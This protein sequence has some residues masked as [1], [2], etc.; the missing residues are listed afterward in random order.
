MSIVYHSRSR[1]SA[2]RRG[3]SPR[4]SRRCR[5]RPA[6][7]WSP[8]GCDRW[9]SSSGDLPGRADGQ[10]AAG[11]RAH[12]GQDQQPVDR[13][14]E[15]Q[16]VVGIQRGFTA[17]AAPR[18]V[19]RRPP[20]ITARGG[21]PADPALRRRRD[22]AGWAASGGG[23][24]AAVSRTGLRAP[25]RHPSVPDGERHRVAHLVGGQ[26]FGQEPDGH[27]LGAQQHGGQRVVEDGPV[28]QV[29]VVPRDGIQPRRDPPARQ[30]QRR[31]VRPARS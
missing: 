23:L 10:D 14:A 13:A 1:W 3:R 4:R 25:G 24:A 17:T 20:Q 16:G 15:W 31:P 2:R 9:R 12:G 11:Q 6:P 26:Q 27:Q 21:G 30:Q 29:Q 18:R 7:G 22:G 28:V 19:N 5:D 8:S